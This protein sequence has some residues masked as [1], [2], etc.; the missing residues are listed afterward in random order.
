MYL[1]NFSV[2][3]HIPSEKDREA[4]TLLLENIKNTRGEVFIPSSNY[5]AFLA[6]KKTYLSTIALAEI[7]GRYGPPVSTQSRAIKTEIRTAM[8]QRIFSLVILDY[9]DTFHAGDLGKRYQQSGILFGDSD[10][11]FPVTGWDNRPETVFV[12]DSP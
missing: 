1:M 9:R 2:T 12:P 10:V 6:G 11:F 4:G 7:I 5:L 8:E 3:N